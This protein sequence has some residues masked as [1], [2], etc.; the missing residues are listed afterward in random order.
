MARHN[1]TAH[2]AAAQML[3]W[4][5]DWNVF[6]SDVFGVSLDKEQREIITAIQHNRRVSVRSGTARGKD[7]LSACAALAFLYL[8][9]RFDANGE[10]VANTKVALTAPTER[11]I[12]NIMMPE[13]SRLFG[14]AKR[15]GFN[16]VGRLTQTDIR[17]PYDEWFLTGFKA[18][19]NNHEAWSGFHA[20]NTMFVV[21]EATGI[22]D[23]T[24]AAIEGNLQGNSRILLV[25]NPNTTTGYAAR[26]Q[27]EER[28]ARFCLNSLNAPNVIAR[29]NLINGQVDYDWI[30][31]K[32]GAWC[33]RIAPD[34]VKRAENDF[35]FDG[36]A[37]R[38]NDLF[39][40]K[41]LGEFPKVAE[42]VLLP[43]A[44]VE[45]AQ[46]RWRTMHGDIDKDAPAVVGV[47]VAGM[48]RD[49]SVKAI[50]QGHIIRAIQKRNSGGKADQMTTAGE[51]LQLLNTFPKL[52]VS[53]DTI[54]EGAGVLSRLQET[55]QGATARRVHSC[56]FSEGAK[57]FGR[58]LTDD[59]TGQYH[60]A[61]MRAF[62]FWSFREWLNPDN[63]TPAILP[64]SQTLL[65]EAAEIT[66]SFKSDGAII[67][68]PKDAIKKR[69]GFS[70][71]EA[72]AIANTFYPA[73]VA[74]V[75]APVDEITPDEYDELLY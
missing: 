53:I 16:L 64:P 32:L 34:D 72:D 21:T 28:W 27:R 46:Q 33:T 66:W 26:S 61:N 7:F 29:Q 10:M 57:R 47:D 25:F 4:R 40:K 74:S 3:A 41:V 44:W 36:V 75:V 6:I 31:D 35:I 5:A 59:A 55:T 9:P 39:R 68:E 43:P 49:N 48:G 69:L 71:D 58:P 52:A 12:K 23:D 19:E 24:F 22:S 50:R 14:R 73:A 51:C 15:R 13:I 17:T 11:Q 38:P 37:Y 45:A 54:G 67:I 8:T 1:A 63:P 70:P 65:Q 20:V 60:F 56:K 2:A 18:D 42:N 30:A 62:L